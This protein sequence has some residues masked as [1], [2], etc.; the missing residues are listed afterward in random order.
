MKRILIAAAIIALIAVA[1]LA[2]RREGIRHALDD[3]EYWVLDFD[4]HDGYDWDL[5]IYLDGEHYVNGMFV[6]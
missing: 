6:G 3:A 1:F 5:H 2:G 4:E